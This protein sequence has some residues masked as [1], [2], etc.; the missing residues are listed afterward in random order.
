MTTQL[1]DDRETA[2]R[3]GYK[4][5]DWSE[6]IAFEDYCS[7]VKDWTIKAI[8]RDDHVIGAVYKKDDE[9][10]V[11]I[12]PEW[13]RIWVT[14]GLLKQLFNGSKI[15]TRVTS[16]HDYMY[17]ILKRL[18]FKESDGGMLVKEN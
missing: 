7:A 16:G 17:D 11:S 8:K 14:K 3:I 18:G 9:L 13:R 12:L 6:P 1:I 2:L 15:T 4:A 10:H 5:T